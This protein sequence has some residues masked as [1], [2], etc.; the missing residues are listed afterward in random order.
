MT[1][2]EWGLHSPRGEAQ[3]EW[4]DPSLPDQPIFTLQECSVES[5]RLPAVRLPRV[6][7]RCTSSLAST[8]RLSRRINMPAEKYL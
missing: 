2:E 4:K 3:E 5:Q 1:V 8:A 7:R 6:A